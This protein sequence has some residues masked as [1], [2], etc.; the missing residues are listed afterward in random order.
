MIGD[1]TEQ[2]ITDAIKL[3]VLYGFHPGAHT[4]WVLMGRKDKAYQ[5]AHPHLKET[6]E[7]FDEL[8]DN[9]R[10]LVPP[11]LLD[12]GLEEFTNFSGIRKMTPDE[13][14]GIEFEMLAMDFIVFN[15]WYLPELGADIK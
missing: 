15:K 9:H 14:A 6:Q 2:N 11:S 10:S 8:Y 7:L 1:R 13:Y 5:V 12:M 4:A 3:W